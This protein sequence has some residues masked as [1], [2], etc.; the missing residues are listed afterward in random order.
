VRHA[1]CRTS[2]CLKSLRRQSWAAMD[3]F[4]IR[5]RPFSLTAGNASSWPHSRSPARQGDCS[6]RPIATSSAGAG[7][8]ACTDGT[9]GRGGPRG[10]NTRDQRGPRHR[11]ASG[12]I[13]PQCQKAC[14]WRAARVGNSFARLSCCPAQPSGAGERR[15]GSVKLTMPYRMPIGVHRSQFSELF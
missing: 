8:G 15:F 13:A 10:T 12:T 9:S 11:C 4:R 1:A 14:R 5:H 7:S 6:G 3:R 2:A